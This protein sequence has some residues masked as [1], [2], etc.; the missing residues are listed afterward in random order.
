MHFSSEVWPQQHPANPPPLL[1]GFTAITDHPRAGEVLSG[2]GPKTDAVP[3]RIPMSFRSQAVQSGGGG[4]GFSVRP[5]LSLFLI[6]K[7]VHS[8]G[9]IPKTVALFDTL[10]KY[11]ER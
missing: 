3:V 5:A 8:S 10:C 1:L 9:Q 7:L 6:G 2:C 4:G 11:R